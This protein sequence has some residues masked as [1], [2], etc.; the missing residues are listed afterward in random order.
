MITTLCKS[1]VATQRYTFFVLLL[2]L[3]G[4][5]CTRAEESKCSS[6]KEFYCPLCGGVE[7]TDCISCEG[8]IFSDQQYGICYDRKL[9]HV[10]GNE[11]GDSDNHYPFLWFDIAASVIWFL[12]AG[13]AVSC[14]VGGGGIYVPMGMILLR[15][16]PKPS[17][18]LSQACIFGAG[19]GGLFINGRKRH[20]DRHIRDTKG[21]PSE[22]GLGKIV[23]YER[24]M[25]H[26]EIE[27]DRKS[28]L[29]GGDGQRKFYT[30][31]VI[32]YDLLLLMAPMELAGAVFGVTVQRVLPDWLFLSFAVVVLG[33]TC[34]K[35][36]KKFKNLHRLEK[37]HLQE[38]ARTTVRHENE[39]NKDPNVVAI[40]D[41]SSDGS[42]SVIH[43]QLW[44]AV[45]SFDEN[46][47]E[48]EDFSRHPDAKLDRDD[49]REL[50]SR[51]AFLEED[52]IQFPKY[53]IASL[54][55]LWVGLS[56][57][58]LLKGDKGAPSLIGLTCEKPGYYALVACQF[59]WTFGFAI[60]FAYRAVRRTEARKAVNYPFNENDILV[61]C[62][63]FLG[64]RRS[65]FHSYFLMHAHSGT[66]SR[67]EIF[68]W[69]ASAVD[70]SLELLAYP[71]VISQARSWY[72]MEFI[73][74]WQLLRVQLR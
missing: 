57:I 68:P 59:L 15:F 52:S 45:L 12:V 23:S 37:E 50:E 17:A 29:Q 61:R 11:L 48:M 43:E 53:K 60:V 49:P 14:G 8:Y 70:L 42:V 7:T 54:I 41:Q 40:D 66:Q 22:E 2:L 31:P 51:R 72:I 6:P 71:Q 73:H 18:G 65:S 28:Y 63:C 69:L 46:D 9:F 10:R 1:S 56:I 33:F 24:N 20:P 30:R 32:D 4:F 25:T 47:S 35:T 27:A 62:K 19:I 3:L 16:P 55:L 67:F 38:I 64:Q 36:Y 34:Y 5:I 21:L 13:I 74:L 44:P 58:Y 39:Q 26:S